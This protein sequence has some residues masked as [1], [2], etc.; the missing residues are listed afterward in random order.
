MI[1]QVQGVVHK[2]TVTNALASMW[3]NP[4][5]DGRYET[6]DQTG[7]GRGCAVRA[8]RWL[9]DRARPREISYPSHSD[10][11][12]ELQRT[13][14]SRLPDPFSTQRKVRSRRH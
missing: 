8:V 12:F 4:G 14:A 6:P 3:G 9:N 1:T 2:D 11:F 10:L 13:H 7:C 5:P